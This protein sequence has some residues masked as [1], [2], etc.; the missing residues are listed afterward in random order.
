MQVYLRISEAQPNFCIREAD[1]KTVQAERKC[2]F[3]PHSTV[4]NMVFLFIYSLKLAF[5]NALH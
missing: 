5:S 1:T 4:E 3:L 2:K